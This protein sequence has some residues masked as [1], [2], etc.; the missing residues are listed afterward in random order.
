MLLRGGGGV[1]IYWL[2]LKRRCFQTV[3]NTL[4]IVSGFSDSNPFSLAQC[5]CGRLVEWF[6]RQPRGWKRKKNEERSHG[7]SWNHVKKVLT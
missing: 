3:K 5:A 4:V 1:L 7:E 2:L 6:L